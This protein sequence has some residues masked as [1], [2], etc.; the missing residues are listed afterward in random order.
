M[1]FKNKNKY[2]FTRLTIVM[3]AIVI[4]MA[5]YLVLQNNL[6]KPLSIFVDK[7][8]LVADG[9]VKV[10]PTTVNLGLSYTSKKYQA[11]L[12]PECKDPFSCNAPI[13]SQIDPKRP[14]GVC[15]YAEVAISTSTHGLVYEAKYKI[16][17][18]AGKEINNGYTPIIPTAATNNTYGLSQGDDACN[19][20]QAKTRKSMVKW[21][22]EL[23][24][25][26]ESDSGLDSE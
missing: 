2:G 5:I 12:S 8:S 19:L 3:F 17:N 23:V 4:I 20:L 6:V 10:N 16:K 11:S 25:V 24:E 26:L 14:A 7:D 1:N 22:D 15:T 9:A 21:L 18:P 13:P